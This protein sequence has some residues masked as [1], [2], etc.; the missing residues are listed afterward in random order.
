MKKLITILVVAIMATS[1]TFAHNEP[2]SASATFTTTVIAP[3]AWSNSGNVDLPVVINGQTR[4]FSSDKTITFNLTG[5]ASYDVTFTKS[6]PDD[7]DGVSLDGSWSA[8]IGSLDASGNAQITY[9]CTGVN[10][11][12]ATST[13]DKTFHL[14][15]TAE[16]SGI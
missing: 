11:E 8:D 12:S 10:A 6:G 1:V 3:L 13:G 7:V 14:E 15:V 4:T 2:Q 9:T 5:E 16:Y